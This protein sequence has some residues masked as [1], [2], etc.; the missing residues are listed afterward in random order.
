MDSLAAFKRILDDDI[1]IWFMWLGSNGWE[2]ANASLFCSFHFFS[3]LSR[4]ICALIFDN[5]GVVCL[6]NYNSMQ[7]SFWIWDFQIVLHILYFFGWLPNSFPYN[8]LYGVY[9]TITCDYCIVFFSVS[10]TACFS[11]DY[12]FEKKGIEEQMPFHIWLAN[13]PKDSTA[14]N[15][16]TMW[17]NKSS[18]IFYCDLTF[19]F[20]NMTC[21]IPLSLIFWLN[22]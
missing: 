20:V 19:S 10:M 18:S 2:L 14:V 22:V 21:G 13:E 4:I 8:S 11:K 1:I 9:D 3:Q 12:T 7:W 15:F 17:I 5:D 6:P 16:V